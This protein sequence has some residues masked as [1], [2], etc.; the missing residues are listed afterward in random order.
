MVAIRCLT[1]VAVVAGTRKSNISIAG[2]PNT[3]NHLV[4]NAMVHDNDV[5]NRLQARGKFAYHLQLQK[6]F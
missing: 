3:D 2:R 1:A 6:N 5:L 4:G